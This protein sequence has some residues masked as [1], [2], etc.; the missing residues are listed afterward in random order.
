MRSPTRT[1]QLSGD[2]LLIFSLSETSRTTDQVPGEHEQE[3]PGLP[4]QPDPDQA[5]VPL[6]RPGFK[7]RVPP[8]GMVPAA[9]CRRLQELEDTGEYDPS[10]PDEPAPPD[11]SIEVVND[12]GT[13]SAPSTGPPVP[14]EEPSSIAPPDEKRR[15]TDHD[16]S[17]LLNVSPRQLINHSD[18]KW[19][20]NLV[21]EENQSWECFETI[22]GDNPDVMTME[23]ELNFTSKWQQKLF[24]RNPTAFLVEKMRDSEVIFSKLS[25]EHR[26]LFTR[27]KTKEV[28]S[29][30]QNQAV[31]KSMND[32]ETKAA[33]SSGRILRQALLRNRSLPETSSTRSPANMAGSWKA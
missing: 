27:A 30:I 20:N 22:L 3:E 15:K 12:Y 4:D 21:V 14:A 28:N 2:R 16:D 19:L 9:V 24:L 26:A 1:T 29:F 25:A 11:P 18:A 10:I 31:R 13:G 7:Q 6:R 5:L 33:L 8:S 23:F 17:D 32:A